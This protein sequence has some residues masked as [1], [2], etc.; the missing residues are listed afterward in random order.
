MLG[1][2]TTVINPV[3]GAEKKFT[4]DY[5]YWSHDGEQARSDGYNECAGEGAVSENFDPACACLSGNPRS[6]CN[7]K[8][9][10]FWFQWQL[11][12]ALD[13]QVYWHLDM[14]R[15]PM[16]QRTQINSVSSMI[17][18]RVCSTTPMRATILASLRLGR[19]AQ[20]NHT[21]WW[22][23]V[24]TRA[25]FRFLA[26]KFSSELKSKRRRMRENISFK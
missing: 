12:Y 4:F 10:K 25:S 21:V 13:L 15:E 26:T 3:D 19:R 9:E 5:S 22:A 8:F 17:W 14:S 6:P 23:T 7:A 11:A 20:A 1:K 2:E 16:V 24:P 18:G